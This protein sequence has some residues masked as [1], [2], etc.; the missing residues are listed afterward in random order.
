VR[1]YIFK[2]LYGS[3]SSEQHLEGTTT[4]RSTIYLIVIGRKWLNGSTLRVWMSAG[5]A[6]DIAWR[7]IISLQKFTKWSTV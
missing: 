5:G 1:K 3:G 4:R 6:P 2:P 7:N